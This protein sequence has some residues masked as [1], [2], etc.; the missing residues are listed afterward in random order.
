[1]PSTTLIAQLGILGF[2]FFMLLNSA[3]IMVYVERKVAARIQ[4]RMG[5]WLVG[6]YGA[7]QPLADRAR[8]RGAAG[9]PRGLDQG[10]RSGSRARRAR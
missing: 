6:P 5:P 9:R 1:M 4:Q 3:A 7:L 8:P 10:L 2:V